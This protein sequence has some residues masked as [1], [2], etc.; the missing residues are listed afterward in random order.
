MSSYYDILEITKNASQDDVKKAYRKKVL[1]CHPDKGGDSEVFKKIQQAYEVL[2]NN[3]ERKKYDQLEDFRKND[4]T[5]SPHFKNI[6][7]NMKKGFP[8]PSFEQF[9]N[10]KTKDLTINIE[11]TLEDLCQRKVKN[12][13]YKTLHPCSCCSNFT[14]CSACQGRGIKL[15]HTSRHG[16]TIVNQ[17]DC[18]TCK[19]TGKIYN[20]CSLCDDGYIVVD[21]N[22]DIHLTPQHE[23]GFEL[24][25]SKQGNQEINKEISDLI[26]IIQYKKHEVFEVKDKDLILI[27]KLSLKEALC[28]FERNFIHPNGR[29]IP[30]LINDVISYKN[31]HVIK[32]YGM[33]DEGNLIIVYDIEFPKLNEKIK[34]AL[35]QILD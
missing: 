23:N 32:G 27:V 25:F 30:M 20:F 15:T 22:I 14:V 8:F 7:E 5:Q 10:R 6:F 21:K 12:I 4:F 2:S 13:A 35:K 16:M 29:R 3:D 9:L 34:D 33:V 19:R 31:R 11:V 28:G 1:I 17:T 18:L 26:C 24:V